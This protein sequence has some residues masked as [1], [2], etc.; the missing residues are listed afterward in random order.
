MTFGYGLIQPYLRLGVTL[1]A[2]W[3]KVDTTATQTVFGS[4]PGN[5]SV[6][7]RLPLANLFNDGRTISVPAD[8]HLRPS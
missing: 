3:D 4:T 5:Y 8:D 6:F 2:E 1:K 7:Q